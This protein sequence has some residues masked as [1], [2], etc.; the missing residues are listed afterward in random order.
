MLDFLLYQHKLVLSSRKKLEM[1]C[2]WVADTQP[3]QHLAVIAVANCNICHGEEFRYNNPSAK[4]GC[5]AACQITA[6]RHTSCA[7]ACSRLMLEVAF[8]IA[9]DVLLSSLSG[10]IVHPWSDLLRSCHKSDHICIQKTSSQS[11]C[12][13]DLQ[14]C[15]LSLSPLPKQRKPRSQSRFAGEGPSLSFHPLS[16]KIPFCAVR[17]RGSARAS[18]SV[19]EPH[20]GHTN[21]TSVQLL[22]LHGCISLIGKCCTD[23]TGQHATLNP[24]TYSTGRTFILAGPKSYIWTVVFKVFKQNSSARIGITL[25]S[26]W[27]ANV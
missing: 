2:R 6:G 14:G 18:A 1:E 12:S 16:H 21:I 25:S 17:G 22:L 7:R 15:A 23:S 3:C 13:N 20:Q 8:R 5:L 24:D 4:P 10:F 26:D 19:T 9:V 27:S 11:H